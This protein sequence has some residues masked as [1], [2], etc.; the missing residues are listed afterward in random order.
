M[1]QIGHPNVPSRSVGHTD[2]CGT[3]AAVVG[4]HRSPRSIE[5]TSPE[6][7]VEARVITAILVVPRL[8]CWNHI[9]CVGYAGRLAR[10]GMLSRV[11]SGQ[12]AVLHTS[13]APHTLHA[14]NGSYEAPDGPRGLLLKHFIKLVI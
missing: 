12:Q 14:V 3:I 11:S 9:L 2:M 4:R 1:W 8:D 10:F 13:V 7:C 5:A 6:T